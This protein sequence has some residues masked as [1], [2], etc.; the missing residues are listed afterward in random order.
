MKQR[1]LLTQHAQEEI[2]RRNIPSDVVDSV[3]HHPQQIVPDS[4][5]NKN[6]FQSQV[7]FSGK[8][9]FVRAVVVENVDPAIVVTGY[10]TSQI[11]SYWR[12]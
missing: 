1:F 12:S 8:L 6:I 9:F 4:S 2:T 11:D 7:D 5:G 3:L 10:R